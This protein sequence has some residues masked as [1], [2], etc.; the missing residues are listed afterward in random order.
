MAS[1]NNYRF[2]CVTED[3]NVFTWGEVAPTLC[4]NDSAHT[5]DLNTLTVIGSVA[6]NDVIVANE[7]N[8]V[9]KQERKTV[10]HYKM[11]PINLTVPAASTR[12]ADR[13]VPDYT[14]GLDW[15]SSLFDGSG[16]VETG[17]EIVCGKLLVGQIAA[18]AADAAQD[19]TTVVLAGPATVLKPTTDGGALD[20]GLF[21]SFG[22]ENT[23]AAGIN[24]APPTATNGRTFSNPD[25]ELRE[26]EIKRIGTPTPIGGGNVTVAITLFTGLAAAV[27]AGTAANLVSNAIP[28]PLMMSAGERL[29]IGG[30]AVTSGNMPSGSKIRVGFTNNGAGS[31]TICGKLIVLYGGS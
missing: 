5:V 16:V 12:Y 3:A 9:I 18:V 21:L 31:K 29:D 1:V 6:S 22:T 17:D 13:V 30:Q 15:L 25:Q 23:T 2:R 19:A 27:T 14:R 8:I 4:P 24:A 26:Y 7:P 28:E 10:G 11:L 20:E